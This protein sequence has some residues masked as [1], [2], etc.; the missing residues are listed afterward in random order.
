MW[1]VEQH[2]LREPFGSEFRRTLEILFF[3]GNVYRPEKEVVV[4]C[5][6]SHMERVRWGITAVDVIW[7][8]CLSPAYSVQRVYSCIHNITHCTP[9]VRGYTDDDDDDDDDDNRPFLHTPCNFLRTNTTN[10]TASPVPTVSP[11]TAYYPWK[12]ACSA[13]G[14]TLV[15]LSQLG[16]R[17]LVTA[18]RILIV[19][20]EILGWV[21]VPGRRRREVTHMAVYSFPGL[22]RTAP[23]ICMGAF[24]ASCGVPSFSRV[25][26]IYRIDC[27]TFG[28]HFPDYRRILSG[29]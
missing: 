8:T 9:T 23:I 10:S 29:Y 24:L 22:H 12:R 2:E 19:D 4:L 16:R 13:C 17:F 11:S 21:S 3:P 15:R 5:F 20:V 18:V 7:K 28:Y 6:W 26:S 27:R 14:L 1:W 25:L